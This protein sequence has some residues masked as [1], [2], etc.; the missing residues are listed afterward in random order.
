MTDQKDDNQDQVPEKKVPEGPPEKSDADGSV[1]LA[2]KYKIGPFKP[3]TRHRGPSGG[4][5]ALA[6]SVEAPKEPFSMAAASI[7]QSA[8]TQTSK[9][10]RNYPGVLPDRK[11]VVLTFHNSDLSMVCATAQSSSRDHGFAFN[12]N[13]MHYRIEFIPVADRHAHAKPAQDHFAICQYSDMHHFRHCKRSMTRQEAT[14]ALDIIE[15]ELNP[16]KKKDLASVLEQ[17]HKNIPASEQAEKDVS[18]E[19]YVEAAK[20]QNATYKGPTSP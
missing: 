16:L 12:R 3:K 4:P 17:L 7:S 18:W 14:Y 6:A 5:S 2:R 15:Q 1:S 11:T 19:D 20:R 8:A 10:A 9:P 13:G